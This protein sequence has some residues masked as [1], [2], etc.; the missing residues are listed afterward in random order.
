MYRLYIFPLLVVLFV[1]SGCGVE[2]QAVVVPQKT[3]PSWYVSPP[4]SNSSEL[5]AVGEGRSKKDAISNAL[6]LMISTLSVSISSSYNAK[7][8]V[9]EG[10]ISSAEGIYK[11]EVKSD[12][13]E[14]RISNYELINAEPIGF[15]K[16]AVL[17]KSNKQKLF[18][19]MLQEIEQNLE[20]IRQNEQT[21][22]GANALKRLAFYRDSKESLQNLPNTLIVM[23]VLNPA[24][25]GAVYLKSMQ[26]ITSKYEKIFSQ[27]SF[28][29]HSDKNALNLKAPIAKALSEKKLKIKHA[30]S[31]MHFSV[32]VKANIEQASSYGFSL[33]RSEIS[34]VT[35]EH[36]GAVVASNSLNIVGQSSQ[37]FDIAKQNVAVKLQALIAKEGIAKIM[38]LDI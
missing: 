34:I 3:L 1:F 32:Y 21:L 33:A 7:T 28:S 25:E 8:I 22:T 9:K 35:M 16:Y 31:D 23:H 20:I 18:E 11:N 38:G 14:I 27:V 29:I 36:N 26:E 2:K 19:S 17:I 37:G 4:L 6:S 15:K 13:K 30:G 12:V 10:R 24:F 5:Y